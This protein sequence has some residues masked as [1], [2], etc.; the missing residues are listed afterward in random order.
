MGQVQRQGVKQARLDSFPSLHNG[1]QE[2]LHG[3]DTLYSLYSMQ[4]TVYTRYKAMFSAHIAN[5]VKFARVRRQWPGQFERRNI[6]PQGEDC[7]ST[8]QA[9]SA[10]AQL[11]ASSN[12]L[13]TLLRCV[14][15]STL[16]AQPD[17][18][19]HLLS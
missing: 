6:H 11:I 10:P 9:P 3:W 16:R 4:Y 15:T 2:A 12:Q 13:H 18:A 5:I 8:I 1:P 19:W 17:R 7:T 14:C